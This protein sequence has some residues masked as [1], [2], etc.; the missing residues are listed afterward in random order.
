MVDQ[1]LYIQFCSYDRKEQY[2]S[3]RLYEKSN[4]CLFLHDF[5]PLCMQLTDI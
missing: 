4:L 2:T 1:I 3:E 5:V